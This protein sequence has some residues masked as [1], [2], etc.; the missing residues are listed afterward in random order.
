MKARLF[1]MSKTEVQEAYTG[2]LQEKKQIIIEAIEKDYFICSGGNEISNGVTVRSKFDIKVKKTEGSGDA[3]SG[4]VGYIHNP[5][6]DEGKKF[7]Y[8][9]AYFSVKK[10]LKI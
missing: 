9:E 10:K 1:I 2:E 7:D 5:F 4:L 8:K 3:L 6:L